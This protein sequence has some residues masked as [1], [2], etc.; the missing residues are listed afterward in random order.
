[1]ITF[2]YYDP[3]PM[4]IETAIKFRKKEQK[5]KRKSNDSRI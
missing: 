3:L 1:M 4:F 5:P 2:Y